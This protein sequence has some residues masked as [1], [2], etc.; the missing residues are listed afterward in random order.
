MQRTLSEERITNSPLHHSVKS[1]GECIGLGWV[2]H[3]C[4][5]I[6]PAD[7]ALCSMCSGDRVAQQITASHRLTQRN[8][9][10]QRVNDLDSTS[11]SLEPSAVAS[12]TSGIDSST[13][14]TQRA[15]S[16]IGEGVAYPR[17]LDNA[18]ELSQ[19]VAAHCNVTSSTSSTP[20]LRRSTDAEKEGDSYEEIAVLTNDL[21]SEDGY[22]EGESVRVLTYAWL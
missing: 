6:N 9:S 15:S 11:V 22:Q 19:P 17:P 13:H 2:C 3:Y 12:A 20:P 5:F 7:L 14:C 21:E 18:S 4:G 10:A 8:T 16:S 1:G